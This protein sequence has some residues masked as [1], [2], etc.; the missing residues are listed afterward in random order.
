MRQRP[1]GDLLNALRQL[2][3]DAVSERDDGCLPV[4]VRSRGLR[5][6]RAELAG[7]VSSQF[8]SALLLAAPYADGR[9]ALIVQSELV[10]Q[11]YVNMT[12]AVMA[13]FGKAGVEKGCTYIGNPATLAAMMSSGKADIQPSAIRRHY[14]TSA[15]YRYRGRHTQ[16]SPTLRRPA[17]FSRRRQSRKDKWPSRDFPATACKATWHSVTA[18][19]RWAA[20]CI[21][22]RSDHRGRPAAARNRR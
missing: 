18:C 10:S 14:K 17:T 3:A 5:G 15:S 8:L 13:A 6:G 4:V 9:V 20:R 11:P 21:C 12:L 2:G 22:R 1:M 7:S 16:S 19:G